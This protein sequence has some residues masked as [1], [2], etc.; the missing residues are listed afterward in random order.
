MG[1]T[2]WQESR[3]ALIHEYLIKQGGSE[4]VVE[5]LLTLRPHTPIYSCLYS[6]QTM[7]QRWQDLTIH[8]SY[9]QAWG[10]SLGVFRENYQGRLQL[11]LPWMPMAYESFDLSGYDCVISNCHA[12]AKGVVTGSQT[13]HICYIQSPTRYLW[14]MTSTYLQQGQTRGWRVPI[15]QWLLHR[16]RQWDVL[17]AQ[18]PDVVWANSRNIQR[19][20]WKF[21]RRR[22]TVL[23]PPVDVDFFQPVDHPSLEYD[24][25]ASRLVPYK[26]VDLAVQA[27]T[28]L[29]RPL[30]VVGEGPQLSRLQQIA[31]PTVEFLPH[32]SRA[33][34]RELFANCRFFLFPWVE[35]FGIIPVEV[36]ACGRPVIALNAGG[37]QE[38]V[39]QGK[40]GILFDDPSSESL[41]QAIQAAEKQD[42]DPKIIRDHAQGFSLQRFQ[43]EADRLIQTAWE[44][45]Q[46]GDLH[47][48][49]GF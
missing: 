19:R 24:L 39:V 10:R 48:Y 41:I 27:Y 16:L 17:A 26:R 11:L 38:T 15:T 18:R 7:P 29:G 36:Q 4:N 31:G 28:Q 42:W 8:T 14:E 9:L 5:A 23:H 44:Q 13:L 47:P 32:Q 45:F 21:Y 22:S 34:L 3:V 49:A 12:Y 1:A 46:A 2:S 37:A 20:I 30:K 43:A 40:T 35:D 25:V 33:D 6:P